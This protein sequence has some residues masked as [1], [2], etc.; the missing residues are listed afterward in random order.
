MNIIISCATLHRVTDLSAE[1]ETGYI[2]FMQTFLPYS[3]FEHSVAV[4]DR[5]RLGKQRIECQQILSAL[6]PN[7]GMPKG[8]TNHPA[9]LQWKGYES[10]LAAY[11]T[12]CINELEARG[13]TNNMMRPYNAAWSVTP[14]YAPE[15][16]TQDARNIVMP[17]WLGDERFHA[18]HRS[19]LL[20]KD[21][22]HYGK[23]RWAEEPKLDYFWPTKEGLI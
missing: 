5:Q 16:F 4:L 9:T 2:T 20:F 8:W 23:F 18:S 13:Y 17:P 11:M 6:I 12:F 7:A 19:A 10:A 15:R 22:A 21:G 3:N 14:G 1:P